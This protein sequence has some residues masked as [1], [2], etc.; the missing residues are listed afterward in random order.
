M[1]NWTLKAGD[2]CHIDVLTGDHARSRKFYEDVFGWQFEG[3]PGT[4]IIGIKTSEDGIESNIG[5]LAE[6]IGA[7]PPASIG[8]IPYILAPEM[9]ATLAAIERA[10]GEILLRTTDLMGYG[11][12]ARFRDPDGNVIGLWRDKPGG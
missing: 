5:G 1:A 9:D 4:E 7:Q 11:D 8:T 2:W 6:E 10:G 12:L 3:Y